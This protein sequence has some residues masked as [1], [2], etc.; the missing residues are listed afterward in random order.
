MDEVS[1]GDCVLRSVLLREYCSTRSVFRG[2]PE[3]SLA[4]L[5]GVRTRMSGLSG[6]GGFKVQL[7]TVC[8]AIGVG[9][10]WSGRV[11]VAGEYASIMVEI[12]RDHNCFR[13]RGSGRRWALDHTVVYVLSACW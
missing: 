4:A 2:L 3:V 13:I 11:S 5:E 8:G 1:Y 9:P 10:R 6:M 7:G 12:P